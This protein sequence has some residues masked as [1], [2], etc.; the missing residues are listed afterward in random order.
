MILAQ[1]T[2]GV[3]TNAISDNLIPD[4]IK[5]AHDIMPNLSAQDDFITLFVLHIAARVASKYWLSGNTG[6]LA[7]IVHLVAVNP[8]SVTPP[9]VPPATK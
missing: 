1:I 6:K 4:I 9:T 2:N 5:V 7:N 8:Q 3:A